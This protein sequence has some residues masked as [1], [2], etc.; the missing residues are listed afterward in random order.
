EKTAFEAIFGRK[1]SLEIVKIF[2][3]TAY[4]EVPKEK[5]KVWDRKG[6]RL[7]LVGYDGF[8][9]KYRLYN[10]ATGKITTERNITFHEYIQ[11]NDAVMSLTPID[12]V[13][14]NYHPGKD[15]NPDAESTDQNPDV[16]DNDPNS[17]E[18]SAHADK[19]KQETPRNSS[20]DTEVLTDDESTPL[21]PQSILTDDE[22][23]PLAGTPSTSGATWRK[24]KLVSKR[25]KTTIPVPGDHSPRC[26]RDRGT[27]KK[28]D[29]YAA[30]LANI[31]EH[32]DLVDEVSS[33]PST[34]EEAIGSK[35]SKHWI[36]AMNDE[37]DSHDTNGTWDLMVYPKDKRIRVLDNRWIY[38]VKYN[39]DGT[40]S[41]YKARLVIRGYRQIKGID[42][43][44]TFASTVRYESIRLLLNIAA[45]QRL[46]I[47]QFDVKTAFLHGDLDE[48]I[49]ME[50]P[51][52]YEVGGNVIC[53][54]KKWTETSTAVLESNVCQF[55]VSI[56]LATI[57]Q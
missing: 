29:Y 45:S 57:N 5:R 33:E 16:S 47:Q 13:E 18:D 30:K 27:L 3:S 14:E 25:R 6:E 35:D 11:E 46:A 21:G 56:Q 48:D 32:S 2:G 8:M 50:Q 4:A 17:D 54:L 19:D 41:T 38:K 15:E 42:Y 43:N 55:F 51:K 31:E 1:P 23:T 36:H 28:P 9:R 12:E 20:A 39:P 49:Y 40:V 22:S 37:M 53:K 34:Y 44:E 52:G 10:E 24:Y 26:L 7:V